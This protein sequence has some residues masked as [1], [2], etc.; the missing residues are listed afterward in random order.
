MQQQFSW[1]VARDRTPACG[2][3]FAATTALVAVSL[4]RVTAVIE[5][6]ADLLLE[7]QDAILAANELDLEA[8][9]TGAY[10]V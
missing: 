2:L 9:K 7:E 3:M 5:K 6:L 4:Y 1:L 8:A 10:R